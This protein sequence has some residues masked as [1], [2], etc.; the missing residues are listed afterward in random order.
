MARVPVEVALDALDFPS[1]VRPGDQV[2]WTQ[3]AG[4][5]VTIVQSLLEQRHSIGPFSVLLGASYVDLVR[6]EHA[7]VIQFRALGAVG[8]AR[9]LVAAG[10]AD[11][12]PCHLSEIAGLLATGAL[13][14]DVV[15]VQLAEH[16]VTG[17]LSFSSVHG[18]VGAALRHA[19]VVVAEI[20]ERAPF[21]STR[22]P[23]DAEQIDFVV[24]TSRDLVE[25][26]GRTP[27]PVDKGIAEHVLGLI[28]D[29]ATIQL[30]IG[31]IP[32]AVSAG[33]TNRRDLSMH[34]GVI[35][36]EVIDLMES[37]ALTNARKPLD[38]GV[39]VT[40]GLI[41]TNRLF[42]F[43][44]H[45]PALAVEP[46]SYTHSHAVLTRLPNLIS[47]NSALE[48]DL[49]GQVGSEVA[50]RSYVGT[51][52]GQVDFVRGSLGSDGG[53]SIIALGSCTSSG[54]SRVVARLT[55]GVATVSRADADV[56]VTEWGVAELRGR[57]LRERVRAMVAIADP[58]F[59]EQL[60]REAAAQVCGMS[61]AG[62][63]A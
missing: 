62:G 15:I 39:T 20:N 24:R 26:P 29:G 8:T 42:D 61:A 46:V 13:R 28:P 63:V 60:E 30:G 23:C 57:T 35:G 48:V 59:R 38:R 1:L 22:H 47:V 21:T 12:L 31:G 54:H 2:L 33:L 36:D 4:E 58:R 17:Q 19:R 32:R 44:H 41:G 45:N 56:V 7:D 37:G 55:S 14:A 25:A 27:S 52:G 43:A 40:G 16:P 49:T 5:P 18:Y 6:P 50:G 3:G 10:A 34:T 9:S 11:V 51:I 53:R